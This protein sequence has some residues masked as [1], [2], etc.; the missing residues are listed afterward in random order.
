[1]PQIESKRLPTVA[2][3]MAL[4]D[5]EGNEAALEAMGNYRIDSTIY[6]VQSGVRGT[7]SIYVAG[8]D[9]YRVDADYGKYGY[10]RTVVNGDRAW[11]ESSFGPFKELRGQLL[12]QAEQGHPYVMTGDWRD[13]F[14]SIKVIRADILDDREV[15][16]VE[17]KAGDLPTMTVFVDAVTGDVLLSKIIS[18]QEGGISIPIT[19]RSEDFREVHDIRTPSRSISS[20]EQTGRTIVEDETIET[21]IRLDDNFFIL[22]PPEE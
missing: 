17:L 7:V 4:R 22:R 11:V 14:D 15:Y 19:V 21:N 3:I 13:Y 12:A 16:V 18:L 20:N 2:E 9:K 6:S 8:P 5:T 1:M 10:N